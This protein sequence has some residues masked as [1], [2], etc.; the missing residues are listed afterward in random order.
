MMTNILSLIKTPKEKK[1]LFTNHDLMN[2]IL[3]LAIEQIL[4][5]LVGMVDTAMVSYAGEAAVS[6]VSLVDMIN[7]LFITILAALATGGAVIVSQY[8]GA[9]HRQ[10]ANKAA[11]QLMTLSLITG[12]LFALI[13]VLGNS[14]ILHLVYG[15]VAPDVMEAAKTYFFITALSFPFLAIYNSS[16]ALYRSMA[17]TNVTMNI[18][19]L[20]NGINIVGNYIGVFVLHMGVAGVAIP[21]LIARMISSLVITGMC[22]NK[23]NEISINFKDMTKFD[24]EMDR[25]VL[26]IA[27]PNGIENGLFMLGK[28]LVTSIVALF[29]TTQIAANGISNSINQ[30]AI[31]IVQANNLAMVTVIGQCIGAGDYEQARYYTKKLMLISYIATGLLTLLVWAILPF[32]LNFYEMTPETRSLTDTLVMMHNIFALLLHPTSFNLSNSI[33][34]AGDAKF[35][36]YAGIISMILFRLGCAYLFGVVFNMGIIGVWIAMGA[37]WLG[38]SVMFVVRYLSGKWTLHKAI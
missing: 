11:S 12:T 37:D 29:G 18:S 7:M 4:V 16:A 8:I 38:R 35:T 32:L 34:A 22:F 28:V 9:N 26:N 31:F 6:G 3:P 20:C 21:T 2:L 33:R 15:S 13:C 24:F 27:V 17:K 1:M 19:L 36:M 5:M 14:A 10:N 30:I 23:K 25:R